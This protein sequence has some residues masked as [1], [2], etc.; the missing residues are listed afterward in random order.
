MKCDF[1]EFEE[2]SSRL[3]TPMDLRGAPRPASDDVNVTD[4]ARL[5]APL[6]DPATWSDAELTSSPPALLPPSPHLSLPP[7]YPPPASLSPSAPLPPPQAGATPRA[8]AGTSQRSA[9]EIDLAL[10]ILGALVADTHLR[11]EHWTL[12]LKADRRHD[13]RACLDDCLA[14]L[15]I[16]PEDRP[17]R[18]L[19]AKAARD[20]RLWDQAS[21]LL[22]VLLDEHQPPGPLDWERIT[23][24]TVAGDERGVTASVARLGLDPAAWQDPDAL[25]LVML[26]GRALVARRVG[27]AAAEV[28]SISAGDRPQ[29]VGDV[30]AF[31]PLPL[32]RGA[33]VGL[34]TFRTLAILRSGRRQ[35]WIARGADPGFAAW[36]DAVAELAGRDWVLRR[37]PTQDAG[38]ADALG[39]VALPAEIEP[40]HVRQY[41]AEVTRHWPQPV[42]WR[43]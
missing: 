34:P 41:L 35:A 23:A 2:T 16:A 15:A 25:V 26:D 11:S 13:P 33:A 37:I 29:H 12:A 28:L 42:L 6:T 8:E 40:A 24:A 27:P 3:G 36:E 38:H 1:P 30:V 22:G 31:D 7:S 18:L 17:A 5:D 4:L 20:L 21:S 39:V 10:E 9:L 19:G 43:S 14:V 32:G